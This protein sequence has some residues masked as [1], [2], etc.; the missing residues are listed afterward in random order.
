MTEAGGVLCAVGGGRGPRLISG[1]P[2]V[3]PCLVPCSALEGGG[4]GALGASAH[5]TPSPRGGCPG[6]WVQGS[7]PHSP[8]GATEVARV[9][10]CCWLFQNLDGSGH[11]GHQPLLH[12]F[13]TSPKSNVLLLRAVLR[14]ASRTVLAATRG[15]ISRP[16]VHVPGG[17]QSRRGLGPRGASR[18]HSFRGRFPGRWGVGAAHRAAS[19]PGTCPGRPV[20][21]E[22]PRPS[23][24]SVSSHGMDR[25]CDGHRDTSVLVRGV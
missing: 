11:T 5:P 9:S 8:H 2:P 13:N 3:T 12:Q 10:V 6:G 24:N 23:G 7:R 14:L 16:A 19:E 18:P 20:A 1:L 15:V 21:A 25:G 17:G 22:K 4:A